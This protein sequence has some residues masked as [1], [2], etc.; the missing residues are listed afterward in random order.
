MM[1]ILKNRK[2]ITV[3]LA[4]IL[5]ALLF[6]LFIKYTER[7]YNPVSWEEVKAAEIKEPIKTWRLG[8][9]AFDLPD[10]ITAKNYR[11]Q[12]YPGCSL[13]S[14]ECYEFFETSSGLSNENTSLFTIEPFLRLSIFA[15][16][17]QKSIRVAE[18]N[19]SEQL[20]FPAGLTIYEFQ[21][22]PDDKKEAIIYYDII[23]QYDGGTLNCAYSAKLSPSVTTEQMDAARLLQEE[24]T[25]NTLKTFLS[26]YH[27]TGQNKAPSKNQMATK[28]GYIEIGEK[29]PQTDFRMFTFFSLKKAQLELYI[30][31]SFTFAEEISKYYIAGLEPFSYEELNNISHDKKKAYIVLSKQIELQSKAQGKFPVTVSFSGLTDSNDIKSQSYIK[32]VYELI[33]RSI[34]LEITD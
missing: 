12:L 33:Q 23:I 22:N 16:N 7:P 31:I 29:L 28:F 4:I 27:W 5:F 14:S 2:A 21:P 3:S 24:S 13:G 9:I 20:G 8:Q 1:S 11:F 32:G 17:N 19:I 30:T 26:A 6:H 10:S 15:R 34:R 25:L 18:K